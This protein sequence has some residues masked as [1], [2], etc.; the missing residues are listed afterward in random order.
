VKWIDEEL[1]HLAARGLLRSPVSLSSP[2]GIYIEINGSSYLNFSSNDYLNL[3]SHPSVLKAAYAALRKYGFGAGSSRLLSGTMSPHMELEAEIARF[4]RTEVAIVFGSGYA[5]N[6]GTIPAIA[7]RSAVVFSDELNHA[8]IIDGIRLSGAEK[9]I[10]R[11]RDMDDLEKLLKIFK[12]RSRKIVITD[13]VFSMDGDIAPLED[14]SYL[15]RKYG[16]MMM[17][18]DAHALGVLGENGRG[19]LE[20]FGI[21]DEDVIQMGTL[22]K[23]AGCMGGYVAGSKSLR[24]LLVNRAR[25][26]MYSTASPPAAAAAASAAIEVINS[27]SKT[28]R[29]KLSANSDRLRKGLKGAGFNTLGS[30][31]QIIP[32]LAESVKNAMRISELLMRNGVFAP[33]IRPPT[34]PEGACRIRFSVTAGH[35]TDDIDRLVNLFSGPGLV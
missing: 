15:A 14:I 8:S 27:R 34:V 3:S 10:Y 13:T 16:A 2:Q 30:E 1:R 24:A 29:K 7:D 35:K 19:G 9:Q 6:V 25:S 4:K 33:A 20:H 32:I 5:A 26:F 22:S 18:D 31:T 12:R 21:E 23:A 17:T 11:H 28:R